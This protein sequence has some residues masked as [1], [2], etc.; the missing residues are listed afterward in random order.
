[1]M[2]KWQQIKQFSNATIS[3]KDYL[4]RSGTNILYPLFKSVLVIF[5]ADSCS[6]LPSSVY[7]VEWQKSTFA[8]VGD[9]SFL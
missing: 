5:S 7:T 3:L 4:E 2:F 1:M 9:K 6:F 8:T